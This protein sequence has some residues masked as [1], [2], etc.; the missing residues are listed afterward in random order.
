MKR[1]EINEMKN[2]KIIGLG[3]GSKT[4]NVLFGQ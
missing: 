4:P 1:D 3:G 2:E